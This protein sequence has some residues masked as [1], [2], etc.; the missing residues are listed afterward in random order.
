MANIHEKLAHIAMPPALILVIAGPELFT[1]VFG[2]SWQQAGQF[3]QWMAP[4]IYI[5]FITSPLSRI[6]AVLEKQVQ[7]LLFQAILFLIRIGGLLIGAYYNHLMLA[8]A[9]FAIGSALCFLGLLMWII[10]VSGNSCNK[11]IKPTASALSWGVILIIPL[12]IAQIASVTFVIWIVCIVMSSM[13]TAAHYINL[14]KK[15]KQL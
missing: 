4:F 10:Y 14:V 15:T 2:E 13:L 7:V 8:V 6:N 3:A 9:L 1:L 5:Q 12:L 11:F